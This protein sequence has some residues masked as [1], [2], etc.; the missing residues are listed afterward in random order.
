[1][2]R[3]SRRAFVLFVLVAPI[4]H[5]VGSVYIETISVVQYTIAD[6]PM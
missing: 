4:D 3:I 6:K 2:S 1:M 5:R